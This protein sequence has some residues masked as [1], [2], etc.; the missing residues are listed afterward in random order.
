MQK[1]F[2]RKLLLLN[3]QPNFVGF[4]MNSR[5]PSHITF[6]P[7]GFSRAA[8]HGPESFITHFSHVSFFSLDFQATNPPSRLWMLFKG[9]IFTLLRQNARQHLAARLQRLDSY[10][11][12][13]KKRKKKRKGKERT[14]KGCRLHSVLSEAVR[15]NICFHVSASAYSKAPVTLLH[16][17]WLG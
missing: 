15:T 14:R 3:Y 17:Q 6:P 2:R 9:N 1:G 8:V 4:P 11:S 16:T 7:P 10:H 12:R 13:H 5:L